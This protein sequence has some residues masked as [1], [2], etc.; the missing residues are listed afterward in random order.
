[1]PGLACLTWPWWRTFRSHVFK[2]MSCL[3]SLG[4]MHG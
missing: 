1:M 3:H 4:C 2:E